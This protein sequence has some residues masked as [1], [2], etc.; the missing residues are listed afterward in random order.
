M[1]PLRG[2]FEWWMAALV[3]SVPPFI[4]S[5]VERRRHQIFVDFDQENVIITDRKGGSDRIVLQTKR[6]NALSTD[7]MAV[8][9]A[10]PGAV[11]QNIVVRLSPDQIFRRRLTLPL[12]AERALRQIVKNEI[13]RRTPFKADQVYFDVRIVNRDAARQE[14]A[15]ELFLAKRA[16]IDEILTI[17]ER[18]NL[19]L[20]RIGIGHGEPNDGIDFLRQDELRQRSLPNLLNICLVGGALLLGALAIYFDYRN[21]EQQAASTS[22]RLIE[23]KAQMIKGIT[24]RKDIERLEHLASYLAQRRQA[25]SPMDVLR[26]LTA[27]L[28]DSI[29]V[30]QLQ[31][32]ANGQT[33]LSGFSRDA[34][35]LVPMFEHSQFFQNPQFRAPVT[36]DSNPSFEQF[37]LSVELKPRSSS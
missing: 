29:W 6:S 5:I 14:L 19:H 27:L 7:P 36:R 33:H 23:V 26:E 11:R 22:Q 31:I 9:N 18:W 2:F 35:A 32:T 21:L 16:L 3:A 8:R 20:R 25:A 30:Y 28:P 12:A 17:A 24:L 1:A 13:D 34:S 37:D 4:R 10:V 15:I